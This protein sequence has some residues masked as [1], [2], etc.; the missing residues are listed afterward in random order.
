[1][2]AVGILTFIYVVNLLGV[3]LAA[4]IQGIFVIILLAALLY[5]AVSGVAALD[6]QNF[7]NITARG[8][9]GLFLGTALLTFTYMGANGIIE[10]GG[11]IINPGQV[12]PRAFF[13]R[14]SDNFNGL[15]A[16]GNRHGG[17]RTR[18]GPAGFK[19]AADQRRPSDTRQNRPAVLRH[20][21]RHTGLDH[22]LECLVY[23][24]DQITVDD[25][26]GPAAA[27]MAGPG[28][29]ALWYAPNYY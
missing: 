6:P 9:P 28:E 2:V 24:R 7:S 1:M 12:I 3:K 25:C 19:R 14:L 18:P 26:S 29:S 27:R 23:R 10:L 17:G 16:G 11:E 15:C 21:R 22:H 4:Q 5:Y 13:D 20:R 8:L